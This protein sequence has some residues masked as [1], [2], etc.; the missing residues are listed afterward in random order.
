[1]KKDSM[2]ITFILLISVNILGLF[3]AIMTAPFFLY[4]DY[5]KKEAEIEYLNRSKHSLDIEVKQ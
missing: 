1:M 4:Q 3:G 5:R 2:K